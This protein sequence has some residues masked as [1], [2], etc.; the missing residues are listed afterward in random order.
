MREAAALAGF[1]PAALD[2]LVAHVRGRPQLALAPRDPRAAA[3]LAAVARTAEFVNG[4][5]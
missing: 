1:S 5:T 4:L 2:D 3:Y